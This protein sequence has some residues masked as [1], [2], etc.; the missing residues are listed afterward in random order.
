MNFGKKGIDKR[1]K[2]VT[3]S[4]S[5]VGNFC[6]ITTFKAVLCLALIVAVV[7]CSTGLGMFRSIIDNSPDISPVDVSPTGY[8]SLLYDTEGNVMATL[9][10]EGSNRKPVSYSQI[11]QN[12]I[13]AFVAIEDSRFWTHNGIDLKGIFR[14]GLIT[15]ATM[16][17]RTEGASTITQQ[18]IKNSIFS[19]GAEKGFGA[20]LERKIQEQYLAVKLEQEMTKEEIITDYLTTI[21]LGNN[22]LGVQSAANRYFGK[23]VWELTL[24]EC[25]VIAAITQNP[26]RYNPI[27]HPD[28]NAERREKVLND[29]YDQGY[30]TEEER[31]E[32]FADTEDV[33]LRISQVNN[34][35]TSENTV[36]DYFTD[37]CIEQ[38]SEALVE[39]LGYTETQAYNM[40]YKGGLRIYTTQD[41]TI[42]SAI[43][44]VVLNEENYPDSC[45]RYAFSGNITVKHQDGT[46]DTY[47]DYEIRSYLRSQDASFTFSFKDMDELNAGV[48]AFLATVSTDTDTVEQNLTYTLQPQ[49]SFTV[50]E[51]GTGY[52]RGIIGGRGE[53]T[54][55][56]SLNR[57][58]DTTRQ[59]GS[60]FK[61]LAAFA[62]ALDIQGATL[63]TVYYDGLFTPPGASRPIQ[64]Y[65]GDEY[66]GFANIRQ[67]IVYSMNVIASSCMVNTT[68]PQLAYQ[69]L[70]NFGFS[71][72]VEN[73]TTSSG[74][75]QSDINASL[76]LGG[77]TDGVT[78]L[79]TCAAYSTIAN[80]GTYVEPVFFT[81][82]TDYNGNVILEYDQET[83]QVLKETTAFL[84]TNAMEETM[85]PQL[86]PK[87]IPSGNIAATGTA[88]DVEGMSIAGKTG[89]T[90]NTY[91]MWFLGYSPYYTAGVWIGY[92]ENEPISRAQNYHK[93]IWSQIMT[94]IHE[95]L[96]DIGFPVPD[97]IETAVICRKS[98]KLAV[99]GVCDSDP[100]GSMVYTEYYAKGTA[101]TDTCD[102]HVEYNVCSSSGKIAGP[103]CPAEGITKQIFMNIPEGYEG[104]TDDTLYQVP[105]D[106][107][108]ATCDVHTAENPSGTQPTAESSNQETQPSQ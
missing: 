78:N 54:T 3:A 12:L 94:K 91:D 92:D 32:A 56:L 105:A 93:R 81:K 1:I 99:E 24:S 13:D 18:L 21:N 42:Q 72:L 82:I 106:L 98:G 97:G 17:T 63:G 79:E 26:S 107:S 86:F 4:R 108:T 101:P 80:G 84:L 46:E 102:K 88:A 48:D 89:T 40:L 19:G 68:T 39:Q 104:T 25:A 10:A 66:T 75:V 8:S 58:T 74:Q 55:S 65:W 43:N 87:T 34:S 95:G 60:V 35:I 59:P 76:A 44:E 61:V 50:I 38:V 16:G 73:R 100:R 15:I 85:D 27:R 20:K 49:I 37:A 33:Y 6:V 9:V 52:V 23:D 77:L 83:R 53:K 22:T 5:R 71:T 2:D 62:P 29:M 28:W 57:A 51:N 45:T 67:S 41:P 11:P 70:T 69:Y 64:N 103:Y 36:Y 96:P 90:S 30:I 31:D 14:A 7:V 47:S